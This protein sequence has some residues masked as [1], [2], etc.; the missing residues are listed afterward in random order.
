M[1]IRNEQCAETEPQTTHQCS[2]E[3]MRTIASRLAD[4]TRTVLYYDGRLRELCAIFH[5]SRTLMRIVK[6]HANKSLGAEE[7]LR[8]GLL[9]LG[10]LR[11]SEFNNGKTSES[12]QFPYIYLYLLFLVCLARVVPQQLKSCHTEPLYNLLKTYWLLVS[13]RIDFKLAT[14]AEF[15]VQDQ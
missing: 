11:Y 2:Q 7:F 9:Q 14:L 10:P 12:A 1:Y 6:L 8:V 4:F 5:T 3:A 15:G 13:Q